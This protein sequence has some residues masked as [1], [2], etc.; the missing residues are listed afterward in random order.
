MH[1]KPP[2]TEERFL[3]SLKE[4]V[5]LV[6]KECVKYSGCVTGV[7]RM[8]PTGVAENDIYWRATAL[9]NGQT[10]NAALEDC[11]RAFKFFES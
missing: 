3:E 9:N 11:C 6:V 1:F 7:K 5:K 4:R 2:T 10:I 8:K